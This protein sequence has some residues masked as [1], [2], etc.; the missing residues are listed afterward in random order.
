MTGVPPDRS[1]P[2]VFRTFN[3]RHRVDVLRGTRFGGRRDPTPSS[4]ERVGNR[5][6]PQIPGGGPGRHRGKDPSGIL[7]RGLGSR[8]PS[9]RPP[10][11]YWVGSGPSS[12]P[13]PDRDGTRRRSEGW[14]VRQRRRFTDGQEGSLLAQ[15]PGLPVERTDLITLRRDVKGTG[16]DEGGR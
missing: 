3:P 13:R 1:H 7:R 12:D 4:N 14:G 16:E 2:S 6:R 5:V 11:C 15:D 10:D 8:E 9:Y